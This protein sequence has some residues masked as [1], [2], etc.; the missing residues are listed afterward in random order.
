MPLVMADSEQINSTQISNHTA[1]T[2]LKT[3]NT[4][5][6]TSSRFTII[7]I[8]TV[9][10]LFLCLI[11]AYAYCEKTKNWNRNNQRSTTDL[12]E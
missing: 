12:R 9:T 5:S 8:S 11:V 3:P 6:N 7:A 1:S 10:A 2:S 4:T